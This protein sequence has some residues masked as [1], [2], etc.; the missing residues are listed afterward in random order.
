MLHFAALEGAPTVVRYGRECR[1]CLWVVVALV[2][3]VV[4]SP[5]LS[6]DASR[7]F[8]FRIISLCTV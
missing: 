5:C 3:S 7:I 2:L 6:M 4:S 1:G 8:M